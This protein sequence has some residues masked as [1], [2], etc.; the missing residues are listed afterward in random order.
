MDRYVNMFVNMFVRRVMSKGINA[1]FKAAETAFTARPAKRNKATAPS[2]DDENEDV[3]AQTAPAQ[4]WGDDVITELPRPEPK[5][6][7]AP[8]TPVVTPAPPPPPPVPAEIAEP[9]V[10]SKAEQAREAVRQA[11][12]AVRP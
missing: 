12:A 7:I 4:P 11:R 3:R 6:H 1:G 2:W 8:P 9:R 5:A 10:I